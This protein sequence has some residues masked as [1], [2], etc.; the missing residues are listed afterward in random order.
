MSRHEF[1]KGAALNQDEMNR[2]HSQLKAQRV[3]ADALVE[4]LRE[5][6]ARQFDFTADTRSIQM[7]PLESEQAER[8]PEVDEV[9]R[10]ESRKPKVVVLPKDKD[11]EWY[12]KFGP[13]AANA[14]AHSQ[15]AA[16]TPIGARYYRHMLENDPLLLAANVNRW[17]DETPDVRMLRSEIIPANGSMPLSF[18]RAFLSKNY[19]RLD[20]LEVM[21][22]MM[23]VLT[24]EQSPWVLTQ[25]GITDIAVHVEARAPQI[26][27]EVRV[28]D[29]VCLAVKITT[30][31][32]GNRAL[33]VSMGFYR[34]IC[35]NL[36]TVPSYTKK[37][38]H[39]GRA[40]NEFVELLSES[41]LRAE[42]QLVIDKMRDVVK[43]MHDA[44]RFAELLRTA[45]DAADRDVAGL[46]S[47]VKAT[48]LLATNASLSEVEG[49]MLWNN[50]MTEGDPT[51][52]GLTNAL[53]ATARTL[54]FE[55][56]SELERF[57]GGLLTERRGWNSYVSAA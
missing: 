43:A 30:G 36:A 17:W 54:E 47:P 48:E 18:A 9:R 50:M 6:K 40:E 25:A 38:V 15:I 3:N 7:V 34:L 16:K 19:R 44:D 31:E 21:D 14:H 4:T 41:T 56:K 52:Y 23:P 5:K 35:S 55:R 20:N 45:T 26:N 2:L 29:E 32:V 8:F 27:G 10:L 42:D 46:K 33:T 57:A 28:G 49:V 22:T 11:E 39:L 1:T 53:T 37:Q 51:V 12:Q 24:D 13:L